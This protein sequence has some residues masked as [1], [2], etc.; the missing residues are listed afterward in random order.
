MSGF[1]LCAGKS[2]RLLLRICYE[3]SHHR[4]LPRF[5][6][7][8]VLDDEWQTIG[9][10]SGYMCTGAPKGLTTSGTRPDAHWLKLEDRVHDKLEMQEDYTQSAD[11]KTLTE[12][13]KSPGSGAIFENVFDKQ[14]INCGCSEPRPEQASPRQVMARP[15]ESRNR[16][17]LP[18]WGSRGRYRPQR[19]HPER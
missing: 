11:A 10:S 3:T 18:E 4:L 19:F 5:P 14:W 8:P 17:H 1:D 2:V 16:P 13:D 7:V 6:V 15:Q 9:E 12:I